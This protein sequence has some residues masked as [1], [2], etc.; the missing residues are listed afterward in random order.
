M[1]WFVAGMTGLLAGVAA[2]RFLIQPPTRLRLT[3]FR[4]WRGDPWP[5]GVQE[6]DGARFDWEGPAKRRRAAIRLGW[7]DIV[8]TPTSS[9]VTDGPDPIGSTVE[10]LAGAG[11]MVEP[12]DPGHVHRITSGGSSG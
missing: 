2:V 11:V 4:P 8:V 9:D 1:V 12:L 10:E 3:V 7:E 5:Q 6:E